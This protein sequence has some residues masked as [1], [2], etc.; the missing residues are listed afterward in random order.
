MDILI[1]FGI[2]AFIILI[3]LL[4]YMISFV[5]KATKLI[6]DTRNQ[7]NKQSEQFSE[8]IEKI[9]VLLSDIH[10]FVN[11]ASE[12]LGKVN[13]MSDR[14]SGLVTKV[15]DKADNLM[16]VFEQIALGTKSMYDSIY[17]PVRSVIDFF[18]NISGNLSFFKS[19]LPK[20]K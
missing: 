19:I 16:S 4:I 14:L 1:L 17:K 8:T 11:L 10:K 13:E 6:E 2:V 12:S 5:K 18:Q 15:D 3:V 9:D 20:K 7:I